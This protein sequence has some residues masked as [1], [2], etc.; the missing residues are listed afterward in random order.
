MVTGMPVIV[1]GV[2][3]VGRQILPLYIAGNLPIASALILIVCTWQEG[4]GIRTLFYVIK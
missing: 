4:V 2:K 1:T 3:Q